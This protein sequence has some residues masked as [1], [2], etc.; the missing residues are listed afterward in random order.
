[1]RGVGDI[2]GIQPDAARLQQLCDT[3]PLHGFTQNARAKQL[4][5]N[6]RAINQ[7]LTIRGV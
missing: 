5:V 4:C 6:R 1:L 2:A 7:D 3:P